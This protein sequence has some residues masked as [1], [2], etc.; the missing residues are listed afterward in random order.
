MTPI[1]RQE[2]AD[3]LKSHDNYLILTHLRPDGD[4]LG[5]AT[6]LCHA[7]RR[8]GKNAWLFPNPETSSFYMD[9]VQPF[10]L[11][12]GQSCETVVAIDI[13]TENRTTMGF[14]G[15]AHLA[16]DH[17]PEGGEF[18]DYACVDPSK[19]AGGELLLEILELLPCG[20][21]S[22][23]ADCLYIAVSTDSGCFRFSNTTA[24]TFRAAARLTDY[25]ANITD[26]N[27]RFF[28][29][30]SRERM[31]LEGAICSSLLSYKDAR[32]NIAVVTLEMMEKA[33][34]KEEDCMDMADLAGMVTTNKVAITVRELRP[35][36]S[37][38]SIRTDGSV[39]A[40][41]IAKAFGG[42]GH[43][44]ASGCEIPMEPFAAAEAIRKVTEELWP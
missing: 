18:C 14:K 13:S 37:K 16:I 12:E 21:D 44:M 9:L 25:G 40:I 10:F 19:A 5:S 30:K 43:P 42:G 3:Y 11:P 33:G 28:R 15:K 20:V 26:L 32:L 4:S 35:A 31:L 36:Y 6:A 7:M 34:A 38:I 1:T 23:E 27:K 29:S 41:T 24:D 17:H 8:M 2:C 39:N 22:F